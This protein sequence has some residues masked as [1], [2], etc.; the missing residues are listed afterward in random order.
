MFKKGIYEKEQT[1]SRVLSASIVTIWKHW[2]DTVNTSLWE[3]HLAEYRVQ[4]KEKQVLFLH[5]FLSQ[6]QVADDIV[7]AIFEKIVFWCTQV[8]LFTNPGLRMWMQHGFIYNQA[9]YFQKENP[10]LKIFRRLNVCKNS[11][12]APS[13]QGCQLV[14][15]ESNNQL[16]EEHKH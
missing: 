6:L 15:G 11:P 9:S 3:S 7:S 16:D 14:M 13:P 5:G 12:P 1:T 10:F 4:D 8:K 2:E